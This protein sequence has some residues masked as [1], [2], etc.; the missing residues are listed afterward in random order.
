M[1]HRAWFR[2]S[3]IVVLLGY[4]AGCGSADDQ[5]TTN[6]I[7]PGTGGATTAGS[8]GKGGGSG[9]DAGV[10]GGSAGMT[11][12]NAGASGGTAGL[13]GRTNAS[14]GSSERTG[15]ASSTVGGTSG[16][17]S[18]GSCTTPTCTDGQPNGNET[19][20]DC[21]GG[22]CAAC[23]PGR[24]CTVSS[25]CTSHVCAGSICSEASCHDTTKNGDETDVDCGGSCPACSTSATCKFAKDC[26]SGVCSTTCRDP[27]CTDTVRNGSETDKDC[28]GSCPACA[29]G[30]NCTQSSDCS[31]LICENVLCTTPSCTDHVLN[32]TE[33]D[34]DCGGGCAG[35]AN[36]L[37]CTNDVDCAD[38]FCSSGTCVKPTCSD[39][40]KNGKETDVDC[41]GNCSGC[42]AA[43]TCKV[44]GDCV[45][46]HCYYGR[47]PA[48]TVEVEAGRVFEVGLGPLDI[49]NGV[50]IEPGG[51]DEFVMGLEGEHGYAILSGGGPSGFTVQKVFK[52]RLM[53]PRLVRD[54]DGDGQVEIL[55]ETQYEQDGNYFQQGWELGRIVNGNVVTI[56]SWLDGMTHFDFADI[57]RD[58]ALDLVLSG[59]YDTTL[60]AK[61]GDGS[62]KLGPL[63]K[64]LELSSANGFPSGA[65][66][67][68]F[69]VVD[70][71]DDANPDLII[72]TGNLL[73]RNLTNYLVHGDGIGSFQV[74]ARQVPEVNN[75]PYDRPYYLAVADLDGNGI[76][77]M[78][79]YEENGVTVRFGNPDG[80][81]SAPLRIPVSAE[82]PQDTTV[83][84]GPD[85][86]VKLYDID[87]DG[88]LEVITGDNTL[89]FWKVAASSATLLSQ[90]DVAATF[91]API[92]FGD[93]DGNG[94]QDVAVVS[95]GR[96]D[97]PGL[98]DNVAVYYQTAPLKFVTHQAVK[99]PF[100]WVNWVT[101]ADVDH[102][103]SDDVVSVYQTVSTYLDDRI[104]GP[105]VT[106]FDHENML[107]QKQI[108]FA[109]N[110]DFS[111]KF[112]T[113]GDFNGDGRIDIAMQGSMQTR[114][115]NQDMLGSFVEGTDLA[116]A[117]AG[118]A[119]DLNVDGR[120]DLVIAKNRS[121]ELY[122]SDVSGVPVL[123]DTLNLGD[124]AQL[125][126]GGLYRQDVDGDGLMDV[127]ATGLT[128]E[129]AQ[130]GGGLLYSGWNN[131]SKTWILRNSGTGHLS[132]TVIDDHAFTFNGD[133]FY[134][135]G[136][137]GAAVGDFD[138]DGVKDLCVGFPELNVFTI[139]Y[140][141]GP[142]GPAKA[143]DCNVLQNPDGV[144]AYDWNGDG[145]DDVAISEFGSSALTFLQSIGRDRCPEL[146]GHYRLSRKPWNI[147]LIRRSP[148]EP[149]AVVGS[150]RL[151]AHILPFRLKPF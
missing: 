95:Y 99:A 5:P 135:G 10:T 34:V 75:A 80:T 151:G 37:H 31:S 111:G 61:F 103:G 50:Q 96:D 129:P 55:F 66:V 86:P 7:R 126:P 40:I 147:E 130:S 36:G 45:G 69:N 145:R 35:C 25:D 107:A 132:M 104:T 21:G 58:G 29:P 100:L 94:L 142:G 105:S 84:Y 28:G 57:N 128:S 139:H 123:G 98:G 47:C 134:Y 76:V 2:A 62:G 26:A 16:T 83:E 68:T 148:T 48:G 133:Q 38:S 102:N 52:D 19:D 70:A 144:V 122:M 87:G 82:V 77:D 92:T 73:S 91:G 117:L 46:G 125:D 116:N 33:K 18:S 49:F 71:D 131:V 137:A 150:G 65:V 9:G 63:Q 143:V 72:Q 12:T 90:I 15:G 39:S 149:P 109:L 4:V 113:T 53:F 44:D 119:V 20:T 56:D 67:S 3:C 140:S 24:N 110:S 64:V 60:W 27:S 120:S 138:G 97:E 108:N 43:R 42:Q 1:L 106:F 13:G 8:G 79:C 6:S 112:D 30:K 41:G 101:A 23:L 118:V 127:I 54:L 78:V 121:I 59:Y 81:F 93:F 74:P 146:H 51:A 32:G 136:A 141:S 14:G 89:R 85:I 115:L 22:K 17:C 11:S 114:I 88:Q 124:N